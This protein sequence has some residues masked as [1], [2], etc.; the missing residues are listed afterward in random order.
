MEQNGASN[1][2]ISPLST[3]NQ[4]HFITQL[5]VVCSIKY[6]KK[7]H[8]QYGPLQSQNI[9]AFPAEKVLAFQDASY[10]GFPH[11]ILAYLLLDLCV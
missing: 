3:I 10:P 11:P 8:G 5:A 2:H 1:K 7:I 4:F 9:V 6:G